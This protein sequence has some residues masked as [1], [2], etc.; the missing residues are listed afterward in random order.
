MLREDIARN[1]T[2]YLANTKL[3]PKFYKCL[4]DDYS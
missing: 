4:G 2:W 1:V 3:R